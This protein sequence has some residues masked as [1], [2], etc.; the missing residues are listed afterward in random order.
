M[1]HRIAMLAIAAVA[2]LGTGAA[3]SAHAMTARSDPHLRPASTFGPVTFLMHDPSGD[4]N[5][6][7]TGGAGN[8]LTVESASSSYCARIT[9]RSDGSAYQLTDGTGK[10]LRANNSNVV[11]IEGAPCSS[12]DTGE[13]WIITSCTQTYPGSGICITGPNSKYRWENVLQNKW[14]MVTGYYPGDKV[15]VGTGGANEWDLD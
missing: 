6:I 1:K 7:T 13:Q 5:C 2:I 3:G 8:Q 11:L 9:A 15:W 14:L 4:Q 10:C 12:K